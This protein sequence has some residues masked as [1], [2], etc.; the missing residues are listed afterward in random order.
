LYLHRKQF[1]FASNTI[2]FSGKNK[3]FSHR[4]Q[5]KNH[6]VSKLVDVKQCFRKTNKNKKNKGKQE[7]KI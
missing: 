7:N 5:N 6:S 2:C 1:V 3:L 4:I